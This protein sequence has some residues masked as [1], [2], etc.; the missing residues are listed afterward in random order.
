MAL[1]DLKGKRYNHLIVL[2][3]GK[4]SKSGGIIWLCRCDCGRKTF[5]Y[6]LRLRN[7]KTR[8][9]GICDL[10][11]EVRGKV[12][13]GM[14]HTPE[15]RC[16]SQMKNRC[17]NPKLKNYKDYGG[18]GIVVCK[19]WVDSFQSFYKDMGNRPSSL[20]SLDRKR[21]DLNYT[22]SNCRWATK[23]EQAKNRRSSVWIEYKGR[24]MIM[25]EWALLLKIP[26]QYISRQIKNKPFCEIYNYYINRNDS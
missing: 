8:S 5:A 23:M 19:R 12:L 9:C 17:Q 18:R 6:T 25:N 21:N 11:Y 4:Y 15:Y 24:K 2:K 20:H 22:K 1:I 14:K 26:R 16:W 13:H 7:N 3:I 10:D